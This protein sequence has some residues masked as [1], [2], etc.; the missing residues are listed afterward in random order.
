MLAYIN[1]KRLIR[2]IDLRLTIGCIELFCNSPRSIRPS[3]ALINR[4][5]HTRYICP[6]T[7]AC[8]PSENQVKSGADS[9]QRSAWT[10]A[11]AAPNF[12]E[13]RPAAGFSSIHR[14]HVSGPLA[15]TVWVCG[16]V[17]WR[18]KLLNT[19]FYVIFL[20]PHA[21]GF[22]STNCQIPAYTVTARYRLVRII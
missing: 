19:L 4:F 10:G 9:Q 13:L 7:P 21:L 18:L 15:L 1:D 22:F 20:T 11:M 8:R 17:T 16:R 6:M 12:I 3:L 14:D 5:T 2:D